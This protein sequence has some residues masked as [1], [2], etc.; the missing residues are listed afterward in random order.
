MGA[1][2]GIK[3]I[4]LSQVLAAPF[5]GYQFALLGAEVIKVE[6]PESPDCARTRG[7]LPELNAKGIGL[8][9]QVQG[10]NKKSLAL[11][12]H[13]EPGRA[14]LLKL[15]ESADV[16]L[17]NYT[18]GALDTLGLGYE[19]LRERNPRIVYCSMTGY[20]DYG[21]K[22]SKGAYDNTIQAASGIIGQSDGYKPGVSFVD[23]AAG[24]SAAFAISAALLQRERTG[25][26]CHIS[27]SMLEV[28]MSLMSPEAAAKQAAPE[29]PKR[30]E[31]GISSFDTADGRLMLGAFKPSQYRKLG[32]CLAELGHDVSLLDRIRDWPDVWQHSD[33]IQVALQDVFA[34]RSADEWEALLEAADVP[35]ER[36]VT[37]DEAVLAPQLVER[38]FYVKSPA[39]PTVTLPLAGFRMTTGGAELHRAPP[40][41]GSDSREVLA[42]GGMSADEIDA[43]FAAGIAK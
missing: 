25:Q 28:A 33:A 8:T 36:V 15:A 21:P 4:E 32:A 13:T 17:E 20:G 27:A 39:D 18:T 5:C 41:L 31:A 3:V 23:Y 38:G 35:V 29:E 7:P 24:Y 19:T 11:D 6:L 14:A 34:L 43:L 16:F 42:T 2:A 9:Y 40:A 37:L 30:R 26:G 12:I 10:G 22:A 1:L